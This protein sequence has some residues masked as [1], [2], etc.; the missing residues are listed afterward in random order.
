MFRLLQHDWLIF[1]SHSTPISKIHLSGPLPSPP[2]ITRGTQNMPS[3]YYASH[4]HRP[5]TPPSFSRLIIKPCGPHPISLSFSPA[6]PSL[7]ITAHTAQIRTSEKVRN[8]TTRSLLFLSSF[9]LW[10][11]VF[12]GR[13]YVKCFGVARLTLSLSAA[14]SFYHHTTA[15]TLLA[16]SP[17]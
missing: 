12:R 16:S 6:P 4:I 8:P 17:S 10:V 9:G 15:P 7:T 1:I 13:H 5:I 11:C 14:T 2:R 3:M